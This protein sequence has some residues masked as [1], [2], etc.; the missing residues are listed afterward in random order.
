[1]ICKSTDQNQNNLTHS[2]DV[3]NITVG[4]TLEMCN[5]SANA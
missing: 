5:E 2:P 3:H 4:H 1:M